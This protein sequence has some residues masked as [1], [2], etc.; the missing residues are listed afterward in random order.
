MLVIAVVSLLRLEVRNSE[1]VKK[2][3]QY[4]GCG[5]RCQ[6]DSVTDVV[7]DS[8]FIFDEHLSTFDGLGCVRAP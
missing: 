6:R 4:R 7:E 1:L 5:G 3:Y 8:S 2:V